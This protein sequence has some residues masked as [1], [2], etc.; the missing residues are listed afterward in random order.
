[1]KSGFHIVAF[2][3]GSISH[4]ST[5]IGKMPLNITSLPGADHQI[6]GSSLQHIQ[7]FLI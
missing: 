6:G 3:Q 5:L 7:E 4:L 2:S 1:M